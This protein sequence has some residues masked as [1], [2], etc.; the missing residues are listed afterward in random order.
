MTWLPHA[1]VQAGMYEPV[2]ALPR[3]HPEAVNSWLP[4]DELDE[5]E[6]TEPGRPEWEE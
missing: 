6:D 1:V 3:L 4:D 2:P 5:P